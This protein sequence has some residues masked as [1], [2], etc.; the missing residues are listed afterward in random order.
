MQQ[1]RLLLH[2]ENLGLGLLLVARGCSIKTLGALLIRVAS[3]WSGRPGS[4]QHHPDGS[5]GVLPFE[6]R[7]HIPQRLAGLAV[8][9]PFVLSVSVF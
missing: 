6:L 3:N 1:S 2:R 9:Q 5:L 4:N 8:S 7:P